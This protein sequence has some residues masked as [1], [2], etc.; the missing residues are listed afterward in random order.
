MKSKILL[1]CFVLVAITELYG[2]LTQNMSIIYITKPLLMLTLSA[3][4]FSYIKQNKNRFS[5]FILLGLIFSIGGDTFLMFDESLYFMI[6]LGCFLITHLFY[7]VAF[8]TYQ[9][10][11]SG[12]IRQKPWSLFPFGIY[13]VGILSFLWNDLNEMIIPVVVYS[14]VI[15]LMAITALNMKNNL[16]S[17]LFIIVFTGILLFMF[18]DSV[19]ALNKFKN[20]TFI[21][22][23]HNLIIMTTYIIAQYLI[24]KSVIVI[25]ENKVGEDKRHF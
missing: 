22:P 14:S 25:N 9:S 1:S 23:Y 19:I 10:L 8:L 20:E 24:I 13:L 11:K 17:N 6:G 4:Y 5:I 3:Y 18:S 2:E 7:I 16:P 21:I 12:F 15:C